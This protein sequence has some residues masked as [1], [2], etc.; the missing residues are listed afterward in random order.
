MGRARRRRAA[1]PG[2]AWSRPAREARAEACAA[3]TTRQ[4]FHLGPGRGPRRAA[5]AGFLHRGPSREARPV[6]SR[7]RSGSGRRGVADDDR[8][9]R[10]GEP[11]ACLAS[12]ADLVDEVIVVDTGSTDRTGD[13]PGPG[14]QVVDFPWVDDFAAARTRR[15]AMPPGTGFSGSMPTTAS[16]P[17]TAP[18]C[19]E[20]L[21]HATGRERRLRDEVPILRGCGERPCH[22][23]RSHPPVPQRAGAP[24]AYRIHEQI[25]LPLRRRGVTSA[26]PTSLSS[27]SA[28]TTPRCA[29]EAARDLRLL[30]LEDHGAPQRPV[31]ALQPGVC[32]SR[33]GQGGRGLAAAEAQWRLGP[34]GLDRAQAIRADRAVPP[35]AW[36]RG[37]RRWRR[38]GGGAS[39]T[40]TTPSCSFRRGLARREQGI[41]PGPRGA[42]PGD[43]RSAGPILRERGRGAARL[44]GAVLSGGDLQRAAATRR[45]R[46]GIGRGAAERPDY[47]P[48][49]LGLAEALVGAP[50][51]CACADAAGC[52][53]R[54]SCPARR[55]ACSCGHALLQEGADFAAASRRCVTCSCSRPARG[56]EPKPS[57]SPCGEPSKLSLD[58]G[59][60]PPHKPITF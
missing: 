56:G 46:K 2:C 20:P 43:Q 32:L 17:R 39:I 11:R 49:Q 47:V 60:R 9:E 50:R 27:M 35:A 55:R 41:S 23:G 54:R 51:F 5:A 18:G 29:T 38:A 59:K 25:L 15:C 31:H 52:A 19:A 45:R 3:G 24:L 57:R 33:A 42:S 36:V 1:V 48:A 14:A 44:Q 13:R 4:P 22:G 10:G 34:G 53:V 26:G 37:P 21:S 7:S 12:V 16:T 58:R 30:H 6:P 8:Q 28:T 40:R